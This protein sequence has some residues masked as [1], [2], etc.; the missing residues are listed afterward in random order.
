MHS[1]TL[2]LLTLTATGI[3]K[4]FPQPK[5]N[6]VLQML[7]KR[8]VSRNETCGGANGHTCPDG[9]CCNQHGYWYVSEKL[10]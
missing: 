2:I 3:A 7:T 1:Y 5:A 6:D 8:T 4:P 9:E 10:C